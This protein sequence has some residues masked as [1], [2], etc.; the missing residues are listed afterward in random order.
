MHVCTHVR[1]NTH[2]QQEKT[3][4]SHVHLNTENNIIIE[5]QWEENNSASNGRETTRKRN[6]S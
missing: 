6:M 1:A 4:D 2:A 5:M 3:E